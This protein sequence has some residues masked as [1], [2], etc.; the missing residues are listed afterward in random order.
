MYNIK[1]SQ[2][3][4]NQY[5]RCVL[6]VIE[7]TQRTPVQLFAER[8]ERGCQIIVFHLFHTID[9]YKAGKCNS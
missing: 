8:Q 4:R 9:T 6:I 7:E 1:K 2:I 5:D 3:I